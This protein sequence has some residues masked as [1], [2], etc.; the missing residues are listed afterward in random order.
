MTTSWSCWDGWTRR[1]RAMTCTAAPAATTPNWPS[2]PR[3]CCTAPSSGA[4]CGA[5]TRTAPTPAGT[6]GHRPARQCRG[7][8]PP[9]QRAHL[10]L[11]H[12]GQT[13]GG[14]PAPGSGA[15]R[16]GPG[17][18]DRG[19]ERCGAD[20]VPEGSGSGSEGRV[21]RAR[22]RRRGTPAARYG[23][24]GHQRGPHRARAGRF[25]GARRRLGRRGGAERTGQPG[26][27]PRRL[28]PD[29][30]RRPPQGRTLRPTGLTSRHVADHRAA[31]LTGRD[32][33]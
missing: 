16:K 8:P 17:G 30:E 6:G 7:P 15:R 18:G 5:W 13:A 9:G 2:T 19:A 25:P 1:A 14:G 27:C 32:G 23:P 11:V 22:R 28:G 20:S 26:P 24:P 3:R 29:G 33:R 12:A 4:A 10:V 31:G 21:R